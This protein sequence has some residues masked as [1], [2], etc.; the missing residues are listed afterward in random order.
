MNETRKMQNNRNSFIYRKL[1]KSIKVSKE[2]GLYEF[3][4]MIDSY[5]CHFSSQK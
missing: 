4:K 1:T 2:K 3:F 5:E